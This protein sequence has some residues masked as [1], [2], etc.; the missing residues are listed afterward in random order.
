[1]I[2]LT[3]LNYWAILVT[4]VVSFSIGGLWYSPLMF[5]NA[6]MAEHGYKEEDLGGAAKAMSITALAG[7]VIAIVLAVLIKH[8]GIEGWRAGLHLGL[9]LG[10][11]LV[12]MIKLS[13]SLFNNYSWK[14]IFIEAGY[15]VVFVVVNC[16]I[17]AV[18]Q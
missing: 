11:G 4:V 3:T 16:V 12:G 2:D 17:L 8:L 7:I 5:A 6:W 18:W 9:M 1:M 13:D 15:R 14:L 10:I